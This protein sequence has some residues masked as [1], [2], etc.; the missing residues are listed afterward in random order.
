M[1]LFGKDYSVGDFFLTSLE[2]SKLVF[3]RMSLDNN[4]NVTN[5]TAPYA[6]FDDYYL[7]CIIRG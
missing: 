4:I 5:F 7:L 3:C 1:Y 2:L 6:H